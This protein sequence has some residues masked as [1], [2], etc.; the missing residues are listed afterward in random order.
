MEGMLLI[1]RSKNVTSSG[2]GSLYRP[3]CFSEAGV[4]MLM[5]VLR[6]ELAT[7]QSKALIRIFRAMKQFHF[8]V[9]ELF[10]HWLFL[11]GGKLGRG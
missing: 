3:W 1:L 5:T 4:Y 11:P 6:G 10:R 2:N 9:A 7:Q 8:P